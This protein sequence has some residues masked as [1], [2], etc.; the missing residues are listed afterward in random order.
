MAPA[1][2]RA[3]CY[4]VLSRDNRDIS[5]APLSEAMF[6]E[7][8]LSQLPLWRKLLQKI[9]MQRNIFRSNEGR[10]FFE[11]TKAV[12]EKNSLRVV[13]FAITDFVFLE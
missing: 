6:V 12:M 7:V 5:T 4:S 2:F 3:V 8:V 11:F 1:S 10:N 13:S 9:V